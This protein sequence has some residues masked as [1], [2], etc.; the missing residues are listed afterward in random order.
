MKYSKVIIT[1]CAAWC[2]FLQSTSATATESSYS[3]DNGMFWIQ[4]GRGVFRAAKVIVLYT[5]DRQWTVREKDPN[6]G[7]VQDW[8]ISNFGERLN[9]SPRNPKSI[10]LIFNRVLYVFSDKAVPKYPKGRDESACLLMAPLIPGVLGDG[11]QSC[12]RLYKQLLSLLR[13]EQM[14]KIARNSDIR[15]HLQLWNSPK[16]E[17]TLPGTSDAPADGKRFPN[18]KRH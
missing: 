1:M 3:R 17:A 18:D 16:L 9:R 15:R 6:F 11:Q 4:F 5:D 7:S 10:N 8:V 12:E 2:L 14:T 13:P